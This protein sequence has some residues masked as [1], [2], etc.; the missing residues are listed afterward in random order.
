MLGEA[1]WAAP[2]CGKQG[3]SLSGGSEVSAHTGKASQPG[4]L[5]S[6]ETPWKG[7]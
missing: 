5:G 1:T 2:I 4:V 7:F 6:K 3:T